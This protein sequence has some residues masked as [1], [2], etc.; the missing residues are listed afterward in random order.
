MKTCRRQILILCKTYPSPSAKYAETSCVAGIADDGAVV[1]LYPVPFRMIE[2]GQQFKKWQWIDAVVQRA[3]DDRRA[4]SH[5]I[6]VD[7]INLGD[8]MPTEGEW[9]ARR[10]WISKIPTYLDFDAME[11]LRASTG[12][13]SI[14]IVKPSRILGLDIRPVD[15][16][17]WT[18]E[19]KDKLLQLQRQGNLF[20]VTERD[21]RLLRKLPF[22]FHYRYECASENGNIKT[23]KHKLVDWEV[24]A[25]FW[26]LWRKHGDEWEEP[27]RQKIEHDL[28]SKDLSLLL[29]TIHRFP[30][31]WLIVSLIYPPKASPE[32]TAQA[33][34]F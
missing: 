17:D 19:E 21:V 20:E 30:D 12:F 25:L 32:S 26:N 18:Q 24:G 9:S 5:R 33:S 28:A 11:N 31:Q 34:L 23:Y 7:T 16:P 15:K 8:V 4:E 13:P 1:R 14:A 3:P 29:G 27:F 6:Y 2:D 10:Q 22:D